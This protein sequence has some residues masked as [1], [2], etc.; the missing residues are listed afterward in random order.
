M[1]AKIESQCKEVCQDIK[2]T[3]DGDLS[4]MEKGATAIFV[5]EE[6]KSSKTIE[7][8]NNMA[9]GFAKLSAGMVDKATLAGVN[10]L[11]AEFQN[12]I[13]NSNLD[14]K[15]KKELK[16]AAKKATKD[17]KRFK[18]IVETKIMS[19][20]SK[21]TAQKEK[22]VARKAAFKANMKKVKTGMKSVGSAGNVAKASRAISRG[23]SGIS[24]FMSAKNPDG[25]LDE[26]KIISGVLDVVDGLA[27]FLPA[28]A[29]IVTGTI[30]S[31][32]GMF[33]GG[34]GPSTEEVIKE[35][36]KKQK[37]FIEEQFSKQEKLFKSLMTQT[38]LESVKAK[39]LGVL[40]ALQ[41]RYHFI[42]A[43]EGLGTC[44][45]DNVVAEIT[46]RVEYFMDQSDAASIKHTFDTYCPHLLSQRKAFESQ[47]VCG[48]LLY[49]YLVIEEKR[50]EILTV[51]ISLLANTEEFEELTHGYLN[52][53]SY[54]KETLEEWIAKTFGVTET[55][56]GLFVYHKGIWIGKQDQMEYV[57]QSLSH[58]GPDLSN[59]KS[60]CMAIGKVFQ[61]LLS[62]INSS[63]TT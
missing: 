1:E 47:Q 29:S 44:L 30:S 38:E 4:T 33:F 61:Y 19:K 55:Y 51:M 42:A 40:D 7:V 27:T 17:P 21:V 16:A 20:Q 25:S 11:N 62:S 50:H 36:F 37:K 58:F 22:V 53:Q 9:S 26:K 14:E 59:K 32:V 39:G 6:E 49:T 45:K 63:S 13:Q 12:Q 10:K 2:K 28:P 8:L 34:G 57:M 3:I 35:E 5:I 52:V 23:A 48:F 18:T 46:E 43:Y 24:K 54:Q 31:I 60:M 41:S 15:D 56:C